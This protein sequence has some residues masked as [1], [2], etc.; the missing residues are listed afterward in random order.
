MNR[1]LIIL[2][3]TLVFNLPTIE[4]QENSNDKASAPTIFVTK[5]DIGDKTLKLIYELRNN[6]NQ[7]IWICESISQAYNFE[8]FFDK[9]NQSL[10][11]RKRMEVPTSKIWR[12][13]PIGKYVR[14][15]QGKKRTESLLLDIPIYPIHIYYSSEKQLQGVAYVKQLTIE[16]GYYVGNLPQ[17]YLD[18]LEGHKNPDD[19]KS[20]I[21][22]MRLGAVADFNSMNESLF[23]RD[24]EVRIRYT[25]QQ[26]KGEK[27]LST[28]IGDL[29]IPYEETRTKPKYASPD[30]TTC[31][32]LEI[33]HEPS[34]IEY[35][36]PYEIEQRLLNKE[37]VDYLRS[38]N[39]VVIE[40]S[41]SISNFANELNQ[42]NNN[43]GGIV[44][45]KSKA[46]V[47]GYQDG[48][49]VVSFIIYD[50]TT[51]ETEKKQRI[52]YLDELQSLRTLTHQIQPFELRIHCASNMKILWYRL[53]FY[54]QT[55]K[56]RIQSLSHYKLDD[57]NT[58]YIP[59]TK[60]NDIAPDMDKVAEE[61]TREY[62][63]RKKCE[64]DKYSI[65]NFVYPMP[66]SWCDAMEAL[67]GWHT[68]EAYFLHMKTH[69][70]PGVN[71]GRSTYAMNPNC[72]YDSLPDTV[73][74]FETKASWNQ[75]GGPDLF[76]FDNHDPKGGCVLLNDG[77][78]K[79]IRTTE[80]LRQ[81][82]WK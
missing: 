54:D 26:F 73:L 43:I 17:M 78:V 33:Q 14:L 49:R 58:V 76:T 42:A 57:L 56:S 38:Q 34:L 39:N 16:I 2:T 74:L 11:I 3:A 19:D 53:R 48:S 37:E 44:S 67:Y 24:D 45:E 40:S 4:K 29:S 5:Q 41:D 8:I 71:E 1:K 32:R 81:L 35:F 12:A 10:V 66:R 79:F 22:N 27:V 51:V 80:E 52:K 59:P 69:V 63:S 77:T 50:D 36:Y 9:D 62:E 30:L 20:K 6:S 70:C 25:Y 68:S 64:E 31:T 15:E 18:M 60:I 28:T 61:I 13:P 55:E 23:R 75:Y 47:I 72:K 7:D 65:I 46:N 21:Q 82:R